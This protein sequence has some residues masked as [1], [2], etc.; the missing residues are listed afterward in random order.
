MILVTLGTQDK[1]FERLLET[2]DK[3]INKGFIKEKVVVQAGNT[4]YESKNMEIHD[5]LTRE[6]YDDLIKKCDLLIT[7]GGVG[8]IL[9]GLNNGK[10]V[11]ATPRLAKY[12]EHVNDHQLQIIEKFDR[13]GYII[14]LRDQN[15]IEDAIK[16]A[17]KF[18]PKKYKSNTDN[19][20][21]HLEEYINNI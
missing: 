12:K 14:P 6:E 8:T 9:S 15:D 2:I 21:D 7:H 4:K 10:V 18:K 20:I 17:K 13:L 16:K 1:T 3:E 5:F 11:I 19:I